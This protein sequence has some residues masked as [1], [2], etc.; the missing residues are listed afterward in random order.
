[1][2][3]VI[4]SSGASEN[5]E[6]RRKTGKSDFRGNLLRLPGTRAPLPPLWVSFALYVYV[7]AVYVYLDAVY[8]Y[9]VP[10][11]EFPIVP[12]DPHYPPPPPETPPPRP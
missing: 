3:G 12:S 6:S 9:V 1:M 8:V 11:S 7:D 10:W 4:P 5:S 2:R